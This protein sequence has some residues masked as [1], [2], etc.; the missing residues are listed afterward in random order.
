MAYLEERLSVP[1]KYIS[2]GLKREETIM[3]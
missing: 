3:R 2:T 1:I